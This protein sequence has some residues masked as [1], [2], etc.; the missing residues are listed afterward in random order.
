MMTASDELL[1]VVV[2]QVY[3]SS[4]N[5]VDRTLV[6]IIE[7]SIEARKFVKEGRLWRTGKALVFTRGKKAIWAYC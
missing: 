3:D 5:L 6:I 2:P 7:E 4:L 1:E